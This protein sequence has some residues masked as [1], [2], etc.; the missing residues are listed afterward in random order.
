MPA[1]QYAISQ[2]THLGK[3]ANRVHKRIGHDCA[4]N[5]A[6]NQQKNGL[7]SNLALRWRG[8]LLLLIAAAVTVT[9]TV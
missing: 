7:A 4:A 2:S 6:G 9:V 8:F 1:M 5:R 3:V